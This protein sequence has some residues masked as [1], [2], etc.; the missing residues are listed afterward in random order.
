VEG[1]EKPLKEGEE[2]KAREDPSP[3]T[4]FW[5]GMHNEIPV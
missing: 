2:V 4:L 1:E 5:R 3:F